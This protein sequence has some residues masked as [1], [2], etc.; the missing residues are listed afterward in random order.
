M[1][2]K[3]MILNLHYGNI[4]KGFD[5]RLHRINRSASNNKEEGDLF[6]LLLNKIKVKNK[7]LLR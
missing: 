2:F 7:L 5:Q 4:E 6:V 1:K 3:T